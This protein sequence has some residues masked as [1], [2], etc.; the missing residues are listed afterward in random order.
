MHESYFRY[1]AAAACVAL[2]AFL[3]AAPAA[4]QDEAVRELEDW[5]ARSSRRSSKPSA[6]RWRVTRR[7]RILPGWRPA[8]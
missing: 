5:S 2:A 8:S 1:V 6:T 4:G 7:P 3:F